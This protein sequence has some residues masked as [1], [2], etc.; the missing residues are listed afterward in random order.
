MASSAELRGEWRWS[1]GANEQQWRIP[2]GSRGLIQSGWSRC[3]VHFNGD[4]SAREAVLLERR[5]EL[6][7]AL[8]LARLGAHCCGRGTVGFSSCAR[9]TVCGAASRVG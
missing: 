6:S 8:G 2:E 9:E 3:R 1:E 4:D 5:C 7:A